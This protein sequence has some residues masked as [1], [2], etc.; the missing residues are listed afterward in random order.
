MHEWGLL[1]YYFFFGILGFLGKRTMQ[2][3]EA[4]KQ[5]E[6]G[7]RN[8][9][10]WPCCISEILRALRYVY[11]HKR[12]F[13]LWLKLFSDK[14]KLGPFLLIN[15]LF[16]CFLILFSGCYTQLHNSIL[17]MAESKQSRDLLKVKQSGRDLKYTKSG[18]V[19][20]MSHEFLAPGQKMTAH[21][22]NRRR[23]SVASQFAHP[24]TGESLKERQVCSYT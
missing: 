1:S 15:L 19:D 9:Y 23:R 11:F 8:F 12:L 7:R 13:I 2:I 5:S 6:S 10:F 17:N 3:I 4:N 16:S 18:L 24:I 21:D 22:K 14:H 20:G